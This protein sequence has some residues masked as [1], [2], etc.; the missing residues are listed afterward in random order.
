MTFIVAMLFLVEDLSNQVKI[1]P[2][3]LYR[4]IGKHNIYQLIYMREY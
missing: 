4:N 3:I 2:V 1:E